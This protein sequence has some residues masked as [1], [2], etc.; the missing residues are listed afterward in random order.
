M[1]Q[2]EREIPHW[3]ALQRAFN[4]YNCEGWGTVQ[5]QPKY[6]LFP[7]NCWLRRIGESRCEEKGIIHT[8]KGELT[9][10]TLYNKKEPS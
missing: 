3:Q 7:I 1:I 2:L 6:D 5:P 8:P 9:A 10:C 4:H